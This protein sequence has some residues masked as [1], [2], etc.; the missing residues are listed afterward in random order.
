[1]KQ[2]GA[3]FATEFTTAQVNTIFEAAKAGH[4]TI[5][6]WAYNRIQNLANFYGYDD[7]HNIAAEERRIKSILTA[8][9]QDDMEAAQAAIDYYTEDTFNLFGRKY[10]EKFDRSL[11]L[12]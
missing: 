9:E 1:M 12:S 3:K 2:Y 5:E 10:Q 11:M 8:I 4:I 6:R 7:N